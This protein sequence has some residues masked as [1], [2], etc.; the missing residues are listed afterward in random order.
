MALFAY[1]IG[2]GGGGI[3]NGPGVDG[4]ERD[5]YVR[6]L[7]DGKMSP[8]PEAMSHTTLVVFSEMCGWTLARGHARSGD[9][10]A[11][12]GYLGETTIFDEA[13]AAYASRAAD[14]NDLDYAVAMRVWAGNSD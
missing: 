2:V 7:W 1:E 8:S 13:I 6:Q 10:F 3:T 9:R 11:I 12:A 14:Q 5:Y 4:V